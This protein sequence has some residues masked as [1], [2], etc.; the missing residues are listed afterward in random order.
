MGTAALKYGLEGAVSAG[1]FSGSRGAW[2]GGLV[3]WWPAAQLRGA[4]RN[5]KETGEYSSK[6]FA[7]LLY[8]LS[9]PACRLRPDASN[10]RVSVALPCPETILFSRPTNRAVDLPRGQLDRLCSATSLHQIPA[11]S[12]PAVTS[13]LSLGLAALLTS[14]FLLWSIH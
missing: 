9:G 5:N 12:Q 4:D 11:A 7:G 13:C 2:S 3:R 8:P 1:R 6:G 10:S 14:S